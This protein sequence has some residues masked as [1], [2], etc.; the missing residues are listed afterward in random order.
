MKKKEYSDEEYSQ[1]IK[2]KNEIS[3][4]WKEETRSPAQQ[5]NTLFSL[6]RTLHLNITKKLICLEIFD[7]HEI[8]LKHSSTFN[9]T[10]NQYPILFFPIF[11]E[12]RGKLFNF[13]DYLKRIH[14]I[15][16]DSIK[17]AIIPKLN[18]LLQNE[19]YNFYFWNS[20][21][22]NIFGG[23]IG[24]EYR[25]RAANLLLALED[26]DTYFKQGIISFIKHNYNFQKHFLNN[27]YMFLRESNGNQVDL[28]GIVKNS[29]LQSMKTLGTHQLKMLTKL[30]DKFQN[31][32]MNAFLHE[33][34]IDSMK[35]WRYS[36]FFTSQ[37]QFFKSS[38]FQEFFQQIQSLDLTF[39]FDQIDQIQ[40]KMRVPF[41]INDA[42]M[43]DQDQFNLTVLDIIIVYLINGQQFA[44]NG[45]QTQVTEINQLKKEH[46]LTEG[47]RYYLISLTAGEELQ[48][49]KEDF[50]ILN[51]ESLTQRWTH[52]NQYCVAERKSPMSFV[53]ES[54]PEELNNDFRFA[55]YCL[56]KKV[57]ERRESL[58]VQK[59]LKPKI[60]TLISVQDYMSTL[61]YLLSIRSLH[62]INSFMIINTKEQCLE[63]I[64]SLYP[65]HFLHTFKCY[66]VKELIKPSE[67]DEEIKNKLNSIIL[68]NFTNIMKAQKIQEYYFDLSG[69][70][71]Q[72]DNNKRDQFESDLSILDFYEISFFI[73]YYST[74]S[75]SFDLHRNASKFQQNENLYTFFENNSCLNYIYSFIESFFG[76]MINQY[77][78]NK[79]IHIDSL[80]QSANTLHYLL[81]QFITNGSVFILSSNKFYQ[82]FSY[83][84]FVQNIFAYSLRTYSENVIEMISN[85]YQ[86]AIQE[87]EK[88]GNQCALLLEAIKRMKSFYSLLTAKPEFE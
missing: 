24:E 8:I 67:S 85:F 64:Y 79:S 40:S 20:T 41:H 87:L 58:T 53:F 31:E 30:R 56:C 71:H 57:K 38:R 43:N 47:F 2:L 50:P 78:S 28:I 61:D 29:L 39:I 75:I 72:N 17:A 80:I 25:E 13:M 23:F 48:Y 49:Q 66:F 44:L 33:V 81:K 83:D 82:S 42:I 32:G 7:I 16:D 19:D 63:H 70:Q 1:F 54:N 86:K 62:F 84:G 4:C 36:P 77:Q 3:S 68:K 21:F 69:N 11:Q 26:N 76:S 6:F 15:K 34:I 27:F 9:V 59:I 5:K 10:Q 18:S 52:Y 46:I 37:D 35:Y 55:Y 12:L 74:T 45:Y 73:K 51:D 22:P 88:Y 60:A 65:T 14:N